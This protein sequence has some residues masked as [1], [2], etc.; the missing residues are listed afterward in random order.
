MGLVYP[1][2][3]RRSSWFY[4]EETLD[5]TVDLGNPGAGIVIVLS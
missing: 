2:E 4:S 1:D 3:N 5:R